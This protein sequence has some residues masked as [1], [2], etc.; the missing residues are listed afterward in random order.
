MAGKSLDEVH[1]SIDTTIAVSWKRRLF[2]FIGPA[3]LV[4]VGYMDP[5]NWAT[6][7]AGGSKYGYSLLWVLVMSNLIAL[8][9]QS[10][11]AR[12]GVVRGKDLAQA[13][14]ETY[15]KSINTS[16]FFLAEI[17]IAA[18]DLAEVLGMAIGLNLLFGLPM[19]I[20]VALAVL[21]TVLIL[22]LQSKGMRYLEAFILS[23][24][25]IIGGSFFIEIWFAKPNLGEVVSGFVP[26]LEDSGA[27][28]IAIGIIGATVMPH[29]LYL[30]SSLVQTRKNRNDESGIKQALKFNFIDSAIALNAAFFVNAAILILSASVFFKNGYH[31]IVEIQQAHQM[32]EPLLGKELAPLLF[33]IAL[34][35]A[36]QSSTITGTLAGQIV[37]EGYLNLRMAP[38]LRRLITRLIAVIPAMLVIYFL[39]DEK[40]GDM[41]VLSQVILSLQLGFAVIPLIHFVSS[42]KEMGQ[43]A[44]SNWQ[45][46]AGWLSA[47]I[48]VLL[49]LKLV[50]DFLADWQAMAHPVLFTTIL[51]LVIAAIGLLLYIAAYPFFNSKKTAKQLIPHGEASLLPP[52]QHKQYKRIG[53]CVDFTDGDVKAI[54]HGIAQG[55][56]QTQFF[57]IHVTESTGAKISGN[58]IRDFEVQH[59]EQQLTAYVQQ[60]AK[61]QIT[62]VGKIGFGIPKNAIPAIVNEYDIDLLVMGSHGHNSFFDFIYGET[63]S[64]VRHRVKCPV[65]AV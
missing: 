39:G 18:C 6:D 4:A 64:A 20:G 24:V 14:R 52:L 58:D 40:V 53:I 1:G 9:L 3:F 54:E 29:N 57:L 49:N 7:I 51:L 36:G 41:L 28:Y 25:I 11:A 31:E 59:D 56:S 37:M 43:F 15:P 61:Q 35:A 23:L 22:F 44:I 63:I 46:F 21:D 65:L 27:L 62:A 10:F 50:F 16:L 12:L 60:L 42:K 5:G 32:L 19:I 47:A 13:S 55:N 38:W 17:A 8:L 26:H 30:H 34:I 45:K 2:L 48:I 33:A